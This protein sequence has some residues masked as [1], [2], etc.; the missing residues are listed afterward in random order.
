VPAIQDILKAM[1]KGE[2]R[3]SPG[4][5]I[6][7]GFLARATNVRFTDGVP[8][9]IR[10]YQALITSTGSRPP[11]GYPVLFAFQHVVGPSRWICMVTQSP[12][13]VGGPS[14]N[15]RNQ[16]W[17]YNDS[18]GSW[19][20]AR[21]FAVSDPKTRFWVCGFGNTKI[22]GGLN[23]V[24][25]PHRLEANGD[26]DLLHRKPILRFEGH[27]TWNGDVALTY[28]TTEGHY[29]RGNMGLRGTFP[30]GAAS[31]VWNEAQGPFDIQS[32]PYSVAPNF[33]TASPGEGQCVINIFCNGGGANVTAGFVRF[34]DS[35]SANYRQFN[36]VG[37]FADG[38]FN[39][40]AVAYSASATVGA[41]PT[42]AAVRVTISVTVAASGSAD[43]T[44]DEL[45]IGYVDGPPGGSSCGETHK[46]ILFVNNPA[47]PFRT[48][49]SNP[50]NP[51]YFTPTDVLDVFDK[52]SGD[53]RIEVRAYKSFFDTLI[54]GTQATLFGVNGSNR[55]TF[56]ISEQAGA[57]GIT[58]HRSLIGFGDTFLYRY[59]NRIYAYNVSQLQT[60]SLPEDPLLDAI[61]EGWQVRG[62][63]WITGRLVAWVLQDNGGSKRILVWDYASGARA[64][65]TWDI[66]ADD[67]VPYVNPAG[68]EQ[69]LA[70]I[71]G[72]LYLLD[73][74]GMMLDSEFTSE[75]Q[76]KWFGAD[77]E[78]AV[79]KWL[80][81]VLAATV[82][83]G[84]S[85]AAS[86]RYADF[87]RQ[88]DTATWS[89]ASTLDATSL[90]EG[91]FFDLGEVARFAQVR[92]QF[93]TSTTIGAR[94]TLLPG[95]TSVT[96]PIG[97]GGWGAEVL[98]GF[99]LTPPLTVKSYVLPRRA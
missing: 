68:V 93:L 41:P 90:E 39:G 8:E 99:R 31:V 98:R 11:D 97:Q 43:L 20:R 40:I 55:D 96:L 2:D 61:A 94:M 19:A 44:L 18:T 42:T 35:A 56:T 87:P 77:T 7:D 80:R 6:P 82:N 65:A 72:G 58:D 37:P 49:F 25:L 70:I 67:L 29:I 47:V 48:H 81:A 74:P 26:V 92:V 27:E 23:T 14:G 10:G 60:V 95:D 34:G 1:N 75:I 4:H 66:M 45:T 17:V 3:K 62:M 38:Q 83:S 78:P 21:N 57:Q 28:D 51:S 53:P 86:W 73:F 63:R 36:F 71:D 76:T 5:L 16:I 59:K 24:Q 91:T 88:F 12:V 30:A 22:F 85:V 32:S 46:S 54:I 15:R 33:A 52:T 50:N 89:A 13:T 69:P 9:R 79:R 64:W 84:G